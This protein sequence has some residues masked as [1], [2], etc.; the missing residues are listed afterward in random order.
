MG[1]TNPQLPLVALYD[2]MMLDQK[3]LEEGVEDKFLA[4]VK[5]SEG[6]KKKTATATAKK[7]KEA[8]V[9]IQRARRDAATKARSNVKEE[10]LEPYKRRIEGLKRSLQAE[11]EC[12]IEAENR[13][14]E[15]ETSLEDKT[16]GWEAIKSSLERTIEDLLI[17]VESERKKNVEID[18]QLK[19]CR[20]NLEE[21]ERKLEVAE[22][23]VRNYAE[24]I[25]V[26]NNNAN[27]DKSIIQGSDGG[28]VNAGC[29]AAPCQPGS[30]PLD[31]TSDYSL[32]SIDSVDTSNDRKK[33][34]GKVR[35]RRSMSFDFANLGHQRT[36]V[37]PH[38]CLECVNDTVIGIS[39]GESDSPKLP[40]CPHQK[41]APGL[42]SVINSR[43]LPVSSTP[44]TERLSRLINQSPAPAYLSE[45][46]Q[47]CFSPMSSSTLLFK[48]ILGSDGGQV[49]NTGRECRK[50]T[51]YQPESGEMS[52][53]LLFKGHTTHRQPQLRHVGL[54]QQQSAQQLQQARQP[55]ESS[56]SGQV[57]QLLPLQP[58]ILAST[59]PAISKSK[60]KQ[61]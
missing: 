46:S 3:I 21:A 58:P 5:T 34:R 16:S 56:Q 44:I 50:E 25:N 47:M 9:S 39:N 6:N 60:L 13:Q 30:D 10:V 45:T 15:A 27:V 18:G 12:R 48:G 40:W 2:Q 1:E 55:H 59:A 43:N 8:E 29:G 28:I 57:P 20:Q 26:M 33:T 38:M 32:S 51:L 14:R 24:L 54:P 31:Q 61:K 19:S 37:E 17:K 23:E 52:S 53:S 49:R 7:L 36:L 42:L 22:A 11:I 41:K 4:Y 35:I